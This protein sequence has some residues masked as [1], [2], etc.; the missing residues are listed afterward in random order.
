MKLFKNKSDIKE[1]Y[2]L[3]IVIDKIVPV[4]G[5]N[6]QSTIS[7]FKVGSDDLLFKAKLECFDFGSGDA[8]RALKMTGELMS[9]DLVKFLK[10][11]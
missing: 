1:G 8:E 9:E 2:I 11:I 4:L 5:Y 3:Y 7:C 10:F 6:S